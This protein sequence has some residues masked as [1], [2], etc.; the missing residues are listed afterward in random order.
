MRLLIEDN[1]GNIHETI[2]D[3]ENCSMFVSGAAIIED[4]KQLVRKHGPKCKKC[5]EPIRYGPCE[6][7]DYSYCKECA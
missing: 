3:L 4:I 7:P 1:D 6:T 2:D 5:G